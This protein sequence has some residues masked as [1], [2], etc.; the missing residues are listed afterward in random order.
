MTSVGGYRNPLH[1][2]NKRKT[3]FSEVIDL[4]AGLVIKGL[5]AVLLWLDGT[6]LISKSIRL[7]CTIKEKLLCEEAVWK[8]NTGACLA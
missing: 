8:L 5:A 6:D 7:H 4:K 2:R 1:L 3:R